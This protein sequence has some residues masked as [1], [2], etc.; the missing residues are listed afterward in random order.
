M[1]IINIPEVLQTILLVAVISSVV[2]MSAL[3]KLKELKFMQQATVI[4]FANLILSGAITIPFSL[5]FFGLDIQSSIWAA[6]ITFIGAPA[7]FKAFKN[8]TP[9]TIET[10]QNKK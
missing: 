4:W 1:E 10:L 6:V 5:F 8:F 2:V 9:A 7:L 3:Q